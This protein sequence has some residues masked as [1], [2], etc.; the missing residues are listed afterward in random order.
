MSKITEDVQRQILDYKKTGHTITATAHKFGVTRSYIWKLS[1]QQKEKEGL[2]HNEKTVKKTFTSEERA[3]VLAYINAG[4][5]EL[6]ASE[7]FG[8]SNSSIYGWKRVAHEGRKSPYAFPK[9]SPN[10]RPIKYETVEISE[11][12][13]VAKSS[14]KI[15]VV[16]SED[17]EKILEVLRGL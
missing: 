17:P 14:S 8:C 12:K 15:A 5:T 16:I 11:P 7:K 6:Q 13:P 1:K 4:H 10:D 9:T 3:N 2:F